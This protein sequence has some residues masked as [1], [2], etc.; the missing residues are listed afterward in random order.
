[1]D[2]ILST[3][4]FIIP[5]FMMYFWIQ[6]MGVTPVVKHSV[7]E[8]GAVVTLAWAP[9]VTLTLTIMNLFHTPITTVESLYSAA[10]SLSFLF[11]FTAVSLVTSFILSLLYVKFIY[12][13]QQ[14]VVN[15][16]RTSIGKT[17]LSMSPSVWEEVFFKNDITVVG[18]AKIGT[19]TPDIYGC[20]D[21][22]SRPFEPKRAIRLIYTN[23][24]KLLV[25]NY[26]IS[27][28]K[29]ILTLMQE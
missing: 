13:V 6:M 16:I 14:L 1:M 15:K 10:E 8:F 12:P 5:G 2:S 20:I 7:P 9:V 18:I 4:V 17:E 3:I 24:V 21:K 27:I 22:V 23:Y 29:S 26:N 28:K 19:D 11:E 25:Q